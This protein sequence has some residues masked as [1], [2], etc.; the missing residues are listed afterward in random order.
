MERQVNQ[1]ARLVDDLLDVARITSGKLE[2]RTEQVDL[3]TVVH[4]AVEAVRPLLDAQAHQLTVSLPAQP[5]PLDADPV[6]LAQVIL[7][8]STMRQSTPKR[9]V[10]SG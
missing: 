3:A 2:L 10:T 1:M 7:N 6:R 4:S 8:L 9:E 5:I